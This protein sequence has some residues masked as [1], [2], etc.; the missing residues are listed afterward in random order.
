MNNPTLRRRRHIPHVIVAGLIT[1][2]LMMIA[3]AANAATYTSAALN[4]TVSGTTVTATTTIKASANTYASLAGI[5]ARSSGGAHYD[6]PL[7]S[8]TL[9]TA[10]TSFTKS[11][12]LPNG[13][14]SYWS[15]AKVGGVWSSIGASKSFTVGSSAAPSGGTNPSGQAMPQ[16]DLPGWKQV[17]KDDFTTNVSPGSFP[18]AYSS[19]WTGY[20]G[21]NDTDNIGRYDLDNISV[22]GG[23]MDIHLRTVNG[24]VQT[25]APAPIVTTPWKGQTY[26]RFTI[27]FKADAVQN[28]KTAWLLWPDSNNWNQ[29]EINFPEGELNSKMM[30]YNH[31][32]NDPVKNCY[33]FDSA[34]QF[35]GGWHTAT[36]EWTPG[37]I[38]FNVDGK[39]G[40]TTS[41]IPSVPL[42]WVL[43]TETSGRPSSSASG[44]I[45]IDWVSV[46]TYTG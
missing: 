7:S 31:C 12:T 23:A 24:Q 11:R 2:M 5:C 34:T 33:W 45:L 14:Y 30:G 29:G 43:Q 41:S 35:S 16:G 3:P 9:T 32:I 39:T 4:A 46:Y 13:T 38:T 6:F 37:K 22:S 40:S 28:F 44:H 25:A 36:I 18:G 1:A 42:H 26:G 19:K 27:R 15:C 17:F 20:D 21:F 10:G 8:A